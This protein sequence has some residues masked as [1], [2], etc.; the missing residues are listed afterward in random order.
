MAPANTLKCLVALLAA[1]LAIESAVVSGLVKPPVPAYHALHLALMAG[2]LG[3]TLALWQGCRGKRDGEASVVLLFAAGLAFTFVGDYVN[4]A[5][6]GIEPVTAKLSWALLLFGLGYS[7]Y[8]AGAA[9][10]LAALQAS[11]HA[12]TPRWV[13]GLIPLILAVNVAGWFTSVADRVQPN[14]VLSYGSFAFNATL[15]VALPWLAIR[16]LLARRFGLDAVAVVLGAI[17]LPFSDLVLFNTWLAEPPGTPISLTL[18]SSN[19]IVYFTGQ[20]LMNVLPAAVVLARRVHTG[21]AAYSTT[22]P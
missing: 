14:P 21:R 7:C 2:L 8:I 22:T 17:L 15:Y 13:W 19:W 4:S 1:S 5:L 12:R 16:Y 9:K 11:S 10:G 20:C 3:I 18:Y 6:S